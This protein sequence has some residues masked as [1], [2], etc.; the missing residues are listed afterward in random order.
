VWV[1]P[2]Q[3]FDL[4]TSLVARYARHA[5]VELQPLSA[6]FGGVLAQEVRWWH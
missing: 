2:L 5:A 3:D 1:F 4:D 6:F